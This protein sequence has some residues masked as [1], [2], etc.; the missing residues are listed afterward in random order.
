M[1]S[2]LLESKKTI[3]NLK[4]WGKKL[5]NEFTYYP[6]EQDWE[7]IF[8]PHLGDKRLDIMKQFILVDSFKLFNDAETRK[9]CHPDVQYDNL[10]Q[11]SNSELAKRLDKQAWGFLSATIIQGEFDQQDLDMVQDHK[12]DDPTLFG[13]YLLMRNCHSLALF[14]YTLC[15]IAFPDKTFQLVTSSQH[16]F[17]TCKQEP[18]VIYDFLWYKLDIPTSRFRWA[19]WTTYDTHEEYVERF[20]K[21]EMPKSRT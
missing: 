10:V 8:V 12:Y 3:E 2:K 15:T 11:F 19:D 13:H 4:N 14:I 5:R 1:E 6:F 20:W 18:S 16:C 9:Y 17:V 21:S 7:K